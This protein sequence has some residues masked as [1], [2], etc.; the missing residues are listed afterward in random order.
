MLLPPLWNERHNP[1]QCYSFSLGMIKS[2]WP[3]STDPSAPWYKTGNMEGQIIRKCKDT[4]NWPEA[5]HIKVI[6]EQV[7]WSICSCKA[8]F[9]SSCTAKHIFFQKNQYCCTSTRDLIKETPLIDREIQRRREE[10][11]PNTWRESNP[12]PLCH[13]A[14]AVY[15]CAL[16]LCYNRC[17]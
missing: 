7:F 1:F 8:C 4:K 3:F 6:K 2:I 16:P 17:P 15:H 12:W 5:L 14:C 9:G 11:K 13:E 10:K